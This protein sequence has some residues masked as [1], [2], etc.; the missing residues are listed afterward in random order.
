MEK[1]IDKSI[2]SL[3]FYQFS[4][5]PT[6]HVPTLT[7]SVRAKA[8]KLVDNEKVTILYAG[9][10]TEQSGVSVL[11]K[12]IEM[13]AKKDHQNLLKFCFFGSGKKL[14]ILRNLD[15]LGVD[16]VINDKIEYDS[17][18]EKS[19]LF[20]I[21]LLSFNDW[22]IYDFWSKLKPVIILS[23]CTNYAFCHCKSHV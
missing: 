5:K 7:N 20:D 19:Y 12:L 1:K 3:P 14:P 11:T 2:T 4:A 16:F 22:A 13:V 6:L 21:G 10:F 17:L 9:G 15:A 18:I 23:R 8:P